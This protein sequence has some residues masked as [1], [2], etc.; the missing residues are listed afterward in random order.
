[1]H[2]LLGIGGIVTIPLFQ[3]IQSPA[4]HIGIAV[5]VVRTSI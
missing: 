3:T 4:T 2:T 5:I 1:M